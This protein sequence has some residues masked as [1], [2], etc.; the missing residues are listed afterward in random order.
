MTSLGI[1]RRE[2]LQTGT[3]AAGAIALGPALI[4]TR[5]RRRPSRR[6]ALRPARTGRRQRAPAPARLQLAPDRQ[7]PG[8]GRQHRLHPAGVPRWPGDV[9][10]PSDG[11]WILVTNSESIAAVGAGTSAIRFSRAGRSPAPTGS[12]AT[13]TTT[14]PAARPLGD[15]ALGEENGSGMIWEADPAGILGAEPRPAL[16]VF[17]HE[18]AAVDPVGG[19]LYLTEDQ[20]DGA[21]TASPRTRIRTSPRARSRRRSSPRTGRSPGARCPTRPRRRPGPPTQPGPGGDALRRRRGIWYA[22]GFLLH[23]QGRQEGLGLRRAGAGSRS[24]STASSPRTPRSTRSTTSPSARSATCSSARTAATWRS[25]SSRR[26]AGRAAA[27]LRRRR[28]RRLRDLRRRLRPF[29]QAPLLHLPAR[30]PARRA[31]APGAVYEITGPFRCQGRRPADLIYGPP[32]GELRPNGRSTPAR[33][34]G[35]RS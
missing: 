13:P 1:S 25:G 24:S 28:P 17:P 23:D 29:G 31:P 35:S 32:A 10:R 21:S 22:R 3:V 20:P 2:L 27:A 5:W 26:T 19:R 34:A 14:A 9:P 11:G 18:A 33:T 16:G 6:V 4:R 7:G 15:V 8:P 12:S 30:V